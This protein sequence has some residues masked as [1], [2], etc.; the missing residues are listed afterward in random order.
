MNRFFVLF[1]LFPIKFFSQTQVIVEEG[2]YYSLFAGFS[3]FAQSDVLGGFVGGSY[4]SYY[5]RTSYFLNGGMHIVYGDT[6]NR[7]EFL[8]EIGA[9]CSF[10]STFS[11]SPPYILPNK[12][13]IALNPQSFRLEGGYTFLDYFDILM[14]YSFPFSKTN[15]VKEVSVRVCIA[16]FRFKKTKW[17]YQTN[18]S[19][20]FL[21]P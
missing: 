5:N 8:P 4:I 11:F 6:K 10:G 2:S 15:S 13:G 14:G 21:S 9:S 19:R 3:S 7:I 17:T 1:L 20:D 18:K 12:L 16:P